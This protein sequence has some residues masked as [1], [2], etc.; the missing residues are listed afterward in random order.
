MSTTAHSSASGSGPGSNLILWTDSEKVTPFSPAYHEQLLRIETVHKHTTKLVERLRCAAQP[1][2]AYR[3]ERLVPSDRNAISERMQLIQAIRDAC[4][5]FDNSKPLQ[6]YAQDLIALQEDIERLHDTYLRRVVLFGVKPIR[7]FLDETYPNLKKLAA[8]VEKFRDKY[9]VLRAKVAK[10]ETQELL[11]KMRV[12]Q[13]EFIDRANALGAGLKEMPIHQTA[14]AKAIDDC[15]RS[16]ADFC[17][18]A[19]K[20]M[21][22]LKPPDYKRR[23]E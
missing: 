12:I 11:I 22:S 14:I 20:L 4:V 1:N 8:E 5:C 2:P 15:A 18:Q 10:G 9:D 13:Q 17:G 6:D 21:D 16:E 3:A 19:V 23:W 7:K